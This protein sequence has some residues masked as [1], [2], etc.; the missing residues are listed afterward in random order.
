MA[1]PT[2]NP[3]KRVLSAL[4]EDSEYKKF[5]R[6]YKGIVESLTV[7]KFVEEAKALHAGRTSRKLHEQK[8]FNPRALIEA[9]T[10]D[11]AVRSRLVEMRVRISIYQSK[12]DEAMDAMKRYMNTEFYDELSE[13]KTQD[14][15]KS[16]VDRVMS[17]PLDVMAD[18]KNL[19]DILDTIIK[20]VD[21]AN[22]HMK[23]V[24][25]ALK[26]LSEA[27]GGKLV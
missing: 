18:I 11:Q 1:K 22:Y 20:D 27:K 9:S 2:S 23:T 25:E 4:K 13:Y 10:K 7:E 8:Q 26:L 3:K 15:K 6:I 17:K 21:Q 24:V 12:L 5:K 19:I 16:L 14:I